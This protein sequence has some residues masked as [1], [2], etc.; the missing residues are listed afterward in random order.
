[1]LTLYVCIC[2]LTCASLRTDAVSPQVNMAGALTFWVFV[3]CHHSVPQ[4]HGP[5]LE[6]CLRDS[7]NSAGSGLCQGSGLTY[8]DCLGRPRSEGVP[9]RGKGKGFTKEGALVGL[10]G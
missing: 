1:M 2:G 4:P 6:L 10:E 7:G 9:A 5:C 8:I 3:Q